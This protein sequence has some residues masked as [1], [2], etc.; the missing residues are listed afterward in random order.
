[1]TKT[2]VHLRKIKR[3][4]KGG[5]ARYEWHLRWHG[6]DGRHYCVKVGDC[7]IMTKRQAE[8]IRRSRQVELDRG[9]IPRDKPKS[10]PLGEF[11]DMHASMIGG[12]RKPAT[13]YEYRLSLQIA[14]EALGPNTPIHTI[15]PADVA[16]LKSRFKGSPATRAKHLSRLRAVFN[17]AKRW[18]F[19]SGDNP[20]AN[21]PMPRFAPRSLRIYSSEE[22]EA[23]LDAA[24]DM[25]WRAFLLI[26]VT[27]G[28]RKEE[29]LN[30]LWRDVDL[31]K[32]TIS[33]NAKRPEAFTGIDGKQ[34]ETLEWS[35]KT[36]AV[37]TIP[38]PDR[39]V[40]AMKLL[41]ADS[42]GS[43]YLF[44]SLSRLAVINAKAQ[45]GVRRGRA[46][47]CN[48]M[49]RSFRKIQVAASEVIE[50]KDWRIGTIHDLRRTYG[51]RMADVVP[52]HVL[53]KWMGHSD[54]SVTATY[55]LH[56]SD[57]HAEAARAAFV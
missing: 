57:G 31:G 8:A 18:G 5:K 47:T 35:P 19:I 46:E 12:D 48:N 37:R 44:V 45:A 22:V 27:A 7:S 36:Y 3:P 49:L 17:H 50:Q 40:E 56:Q 33:I 25:W 32:R 6:T 2:S 9:E 42:D 28:P 16:R 10:I 53:Q 13:L 15:T 24:P 20:F 39:T 4:L 38:I 1:M 21:Q 14:A 30:L 29:I 41:K 23:M 52:M 54:V 55:Y 51:S 43:P 11:A 34:Y 26:A